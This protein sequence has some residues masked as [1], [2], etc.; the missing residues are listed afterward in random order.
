MKV[1]LNWL[2]EL[3]DLPEVSTSEIVHLLT[4]SGLE[5]EE[6]SDQSELYKN[7]GKTSGRHRYLIRCEPQ[8][9]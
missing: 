4:M 6:V 2:K 7:F 3:V 5:V 9:G 1:S 8:Y